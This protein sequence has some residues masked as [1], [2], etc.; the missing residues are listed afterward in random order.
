M[1]V[2][3]GVAL[4]LSL[5]MR[6]HRPWGKL[7]FKMWPPWIHVN[8]KET[9]PSRHKQVTKSGWIPLVYSSNVAAASR[10]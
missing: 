2:V 6:L 7:A 9:G 3:A 8:A 4:F 1:E 10:S 5:R